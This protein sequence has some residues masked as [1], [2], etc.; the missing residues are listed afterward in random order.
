[1]AMIKTFKLFISHGFKSNEDYLRLVEILDS[2]FPYG[3]AVISVPSDLR[4]RKM[5]KS[6]L[7]GELR[8][9]I[10]NANCFIAL[11]C[12]YLEENDWARYELD[13]AVSLGKPILALRERNS[14][15]V[16]KVLDNVANVTLGWNPE[17][18]A[19]AI[20]NYSVP[21]QINLK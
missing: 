14:R 4:Y 15:G 8:K 3:H 11:D 9:Q 1:M 2:S 18:L 17:S 21:V 13:Y 10:K 7:E 5:T 20:L 12:L 16:S 19:S 6:A